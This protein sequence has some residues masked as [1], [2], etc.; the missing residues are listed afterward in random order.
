M[1]PI[2]APSVV[3]ASSTGL[4]KPPPQIRSIPLPSRRARS[5]GSEAF[6]HRAL[7]SRDLIAV[8]PIG[9]GQPPIGSEERPVDIAPVAVETEPADQGLAPV[10]LP[11]VVVVLESPQVGV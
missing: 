10:G 9:P 7:A 11:I 5:E 4:S 2:S 6:E 8:P 1:V 3:K